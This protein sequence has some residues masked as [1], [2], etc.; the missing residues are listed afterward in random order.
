MHI[1]DYMQRKQV[2]P[3]S[4][5]VVKAADLGMNSTSFDALVKG[6]LED[7]GGDGFTVGIPH[8]DSTTG[9]HLYDLVWL[10]R[11]PE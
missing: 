2:P 1:R 4:K 7:G 5:F 3:G 8:K 9:Q 10:T 11:D 6:W